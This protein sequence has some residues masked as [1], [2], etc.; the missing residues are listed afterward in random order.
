MLDPAIQHFRR[1]LPVRERERFFWLFGIRAAT[2]SPLADR[3]EGIRWIGASSDPEMER[4]KARSGKGRY[5]ALRAMLRSEEPEVSLLAVFPTIEDAEGAAR[6]LIERL[7]TNRVPLLN[8]EP[9]YIRRL[10]H[11]EILFPS[12]PLNVPKG[13]PVVKVVDP[14]ALGKTPY[15]TSRLAVLPERLPVPILLH[16]AEKKFGRRPEEWKP[17][18]LF[19]FWIDGNPSNEVPENIAVAI[20]HEDRF[21][22]SSVEPVLEET[23]N[24]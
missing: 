16:L 15:T 1:F 14:V 18:G 19:P 23:T 6:R 13:L 12:K 10:G 11:R 22:G 8:P 2:Q 21:R 9:G 20:R 5:L 7:L 3:F 4:R 17:A 24:A